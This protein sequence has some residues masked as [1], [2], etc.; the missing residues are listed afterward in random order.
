MTKYMTFFYTNNPKV[1]KISLLE[2]PKKFR[3]K[4]NLRLTLDYKKD[5]IFHKKLSFPYLKSF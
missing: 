1:F 3:V 2:P 5:L 4:G